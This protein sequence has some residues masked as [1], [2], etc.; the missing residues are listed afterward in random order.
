MQLIRAP[1]QLL[2]VFKCSSWKSLNA[3]PG[4]VF[5]M[6]L[7]GEQTQLIGAQLQLICSSLRSSNAAHLSSNAAHL[8]FV[9]GNKRGGGVVKRVDG[10][11]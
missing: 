3:A 4:A 11:G 2:S 10:V 7:L 5:F 6:Q 8:G 9:R 1:L